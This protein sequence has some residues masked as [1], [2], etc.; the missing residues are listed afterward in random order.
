MPTIR[1]L[2]LAIDSTILAIAIQHRPNLSLHWLRRINFSSGPA[3]DCAD[4][5]KEAEFKE[6]SIGYDL[7]ISSVNP[8]DWRL[9][10]QERKTGLVHIFRRESIIDTPCAR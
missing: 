2:N 4:L 8:Q 5:P 9:L 3:R 10:V 6:R 1:Y 7:V